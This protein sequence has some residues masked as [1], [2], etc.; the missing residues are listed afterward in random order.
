MRLESA[1]LKIMAQAVYELRI[2]L[3]EHLGS[4]NEENTCESIAAHL[5]YALHNDALAIIEGHPE[6]FHIEKSIKNI[7]RVDELF[8]E[9]FSERFQSLVRENE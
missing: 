6:D 3:S 4:K 1:Q 7:S 2:L 5:V 9:Q 8:G